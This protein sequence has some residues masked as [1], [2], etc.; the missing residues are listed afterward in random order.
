MGKLSLH[1]KRKKSE[2]NT[3]GLTHLSPLS[4]RRISGHIVPSVRKFGVLSDRWNWA[5]TRSNSIL[6]S[7]FSLLSQVQHHTGKSTGKPPLIFVSSCGNFNDV[8]RNVR[9]SWAVFSICLT[10]LRSGH[11]PDLCPRSSQPCTSPWLK[12]KSPAPRETRGATCHYSWSFHFINSRRSHTACS[13]TSS[14]M[15]WALPRRDKPVL[16][17]EEDAHSSPC[18]SSNNHS[19]SLEQR[20]HS[21]CIAE[22][23]QSCINSLHCHFSSAFRTTPQW[24]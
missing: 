20:L 16:D 15:L 1:S 24:S 21:N 18:D 2:R 3:R 12:R 4:D 8:S 13:T 17:G 10:S 11:P 6:W 22:V 23:S 7:M 14:S 19:W 5:I 9:K